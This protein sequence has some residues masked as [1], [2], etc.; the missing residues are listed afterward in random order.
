M[1]T[2]EF[3]YAGASQHDK[4]VSVIGEFGGVVLRNF[5]LRGELEAVKEEVLAQPLEAIDRVHGQVHEQY[6]C[7]E[8][9]LTEAPTR[10]ER[11]AKSM[12]RVISDGYLPWQ[13]NMVRAQLYNPG[14][15]A[16]GWHLDFKSSSRI[17]VGVANIFGYAQFDMQT[18]AG[19]QSVILGPGDVAFLRHTDF[20]PG[21]DDRIK[22]RVLAP[23]EGQRLSIGLRQELKR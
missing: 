5:S 16:V 2:I 1:E 8:W 6:E 14:E 15:A 13:P 9:P 23:T 19:E 4:Y 11:L 18:D 17:A 3:E 7:I 10:V 20:F 22:H 12:C 21:G